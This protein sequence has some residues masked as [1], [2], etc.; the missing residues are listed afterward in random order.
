M[1][2]RPDQWRDAHRGWFCMS[3]ADKNSQWDD[4]YDFIIVGSGGGSMCAALACKTLGRR[5]LIIEKLPKVGGST[6]YSGGV[7]WI[8]NNPVMKRHGVD[9]SYE[10]ARQYL[11]AVA[12]Y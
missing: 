9:D 2:V 7:W 5:A 6:G 8:P 4:A 11:D 10:K 12:T 1:Y 3:T